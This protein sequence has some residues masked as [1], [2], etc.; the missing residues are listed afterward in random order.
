MIGVLL[1]SV[2]RLVD[3]GRLVGPERGAERDHLRRLAVDPVGDAADRLVALGERLL[4][5]DLAAE[6]LEAEREGLADVVTDSL[7]V[8][9][10]N[11][12]Q[13]FDAQ[14]FQQLGG[15]IVDQESFTQGDKT[16]GS[17]AS[18]ING[19]PAQMIAFCTSFGTDQPAFVRRPADAPRATTRR[20]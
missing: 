15:K 11:V 18:R 7:L 3:E 9:F 6:L 16:I 20:S 10:Q 5:D 4:V 13:A 12:C 8:Y 1:P 14:R 17:V 19:K 2:R